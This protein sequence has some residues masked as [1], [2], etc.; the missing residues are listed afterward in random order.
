MTLSIVSMQCF[1][2]FIFAYSFLTQNKSLSKWHF[3]PL[4]KISSIPEKDNDCLSFSLQRCQRDIS[5]LVQPQKS[6]QIFHRLHLAQ[7]QQCSL[8]LRKL[9]EIRDWSMFH[10]WPEAAAAPSAYRSPQAEQ[11]LTA[12]TAAAA[13]RT[14]PDVRQRRWMRK[15]GLLFGQGAGAG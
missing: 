9:R 15:T 11:S 3:S 12:A 7:M 10:V 14:G 6:L 1:V 13:T 5:L 8:P 2:G 4:V